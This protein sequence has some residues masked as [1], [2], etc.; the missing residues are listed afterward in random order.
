[1]QNNGRELAVRQI[2]KYVFIVPFNLNI[3]KFSP[4]QEFF[5]M[6]LMAPVRQIDSI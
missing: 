1:L 3:C 6:L 2:N 5:C 4:I